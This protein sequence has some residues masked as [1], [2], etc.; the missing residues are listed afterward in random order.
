MR[1]HVILAAVI[2]MIGMTGVAF[3]GGPA[4]VPEPASLA[5]LAG[6]ALGV[7]LLRRRG[8]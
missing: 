4:A 3:A 5:L 6:G 7:L 1:I 2:A 8:K